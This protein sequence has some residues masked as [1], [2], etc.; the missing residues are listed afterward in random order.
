[1]F[2]LASP[3]HRMLKTMCGNFV[4][5]YVAPPSGGHLLESGMPACKRALHIRGINVL[6]WMEFRM[7]FLPS[8]DT[9]IS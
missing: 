4:L 3:K 5:V 6:I 2:R 9:L 1:M 8:L 7:I